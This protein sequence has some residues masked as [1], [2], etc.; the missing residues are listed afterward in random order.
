[1]RYVS[2]QLGIGGWQSFDAQ[3]VEK[4][5]YGDCKALSTF[6]K[7]ML[8]EAGIESYQTLIKWDEQDKL[9]FEDYVTLDF[10]HMMLYIPSEDIWLEC[11]SNNFPTGVIDKDE[12]DKKVL[13]I[14]PDGGKIAT[15]PKSPIEVNQTISVDSIFFA[16]NVIINGKIKYSGSDQRLVRGLYYN[17]S[18][19]EQRKY[20]LENFSL[21]VKKLDSF[22]IFVDPTEFVST[23][24][25][26]INLDHYGNISGERYFIPLNGIHPVQNPCHGNTS[27]TTD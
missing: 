6:M 20:F 17:A 24:N 18:V 25:Y 12:E 22:Q 27:R 21:H 9:F 16:E 13:L 2:I 11:T 23:I 3:F 7:G 19:S 5:R 4:N 14:T 10:N 1:M 26:E 8:K 15:T